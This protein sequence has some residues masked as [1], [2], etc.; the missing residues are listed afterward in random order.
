L[1]LLTSPSVYPVSYA[2]P[3]SAPSVGNNREPSPSPGTT[4]VLEGIL[5]TTF[6]GMLAESSFPLDVVATFLSPLF[7]VF[8]FFAGALETSTYSV[9]TSGTT[10]LFFLAF[11]YI[12]SSS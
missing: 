7:P 12:G 10:S 4:T 9:D 1:W 8:R 2:P 11:F 5:G 6:V 3:K